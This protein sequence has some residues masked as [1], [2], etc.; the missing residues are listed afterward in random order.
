M[1]LIDTKVSALNLTN[2]LIGNTDLH[3]KID[4]TYNISP[5]EN[6]K[7]LAVGKIDL[8]MEDTNDDNDY[9]F[10][11]K[12]TFQGV[13]KYTFGEELEKQSFSLIYADLKKFISSLSKNLGLPSLDL[14]DISLEKQTSD[15][16][17]FVPDSSE[18]LS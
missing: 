11:I 13:V 10:I 12:T 18:S 4:I 2:N 15:T 3:L 6:Q 16:N 1:Q 7:N 9:P 14:P 8:N 17:T 5:A